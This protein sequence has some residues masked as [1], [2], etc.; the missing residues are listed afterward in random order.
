MSIFPK[1][2]SRGDFDLLI[3]GLNDFRRIQYV[4]LFS[5]LKAVIDLKKHVR[6]VRH[7]PRRLIAL[8]DLTA[9]IAFFGLA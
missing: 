6:S 3:V 7:T 2:A 4:E 9:Y 1:E 5:N 8:K